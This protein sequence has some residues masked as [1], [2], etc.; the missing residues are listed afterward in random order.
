MLKFQI[1]KKVT[2]CKFILWEIKQLL[3]EFYIEYIN[4]LIFFF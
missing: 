3:Q 2:L 4:K 1:S